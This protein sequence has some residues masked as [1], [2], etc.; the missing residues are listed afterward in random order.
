MA[1]STYYPKCFRLGQS[2]WAVDATTS[3]VL[4]AY[5]GFAVLAAPGL[6]RRA[7]QSQLY[8]LTIAF[9]TAL[10]KAAFVTLIVPWP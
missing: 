10:R 2:S 1:Q 9:A 8:E 5:I 6:L 7:D 4:M 3:G